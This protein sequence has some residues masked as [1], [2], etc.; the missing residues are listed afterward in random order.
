LNPLK[1]IWC[2]VIENINKFG[3]VS[4]KISKKV[5]EAFIVVILSF[6]IKI[7]RLLSFNFTIILLL[8]K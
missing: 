8:S 1:R 3:F 7:E 5:T 6:N 2:Y 4:Y